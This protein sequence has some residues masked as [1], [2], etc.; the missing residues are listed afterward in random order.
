MKFALWVA[1]CKTP[2]C[3]TCH[4]AKIIGAHEGQRG[5]ALPD[6]IPVLFDF[7]CQACGNRHTYTHADLKVQ[8]QEFLPHY[9]PPEW[10]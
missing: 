3:H 7:Q 8:I 9:G 5:H 4:V 2:G 1:Y 10:W 6:D